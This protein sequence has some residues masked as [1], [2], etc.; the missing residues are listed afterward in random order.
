M[1]RRAI[2]PVLTSGVLAAFAVIAMVLTGVVP[3]SA[4]AP[5]ASQQTFLTF[6]GWWDNTPPG[7]DISHPGKHQTAGGVGTFDDP[8]TFATSTKEV[9]PGG[10]IYVPRVG[11]Y[12]IMEDDCD[13]CSSDWNGKGPNGGPKLAHF[14][15][16]LGGKGG[17]PFKAIQCE[18]ALTHYNKDNTPTMEP[19]IVDPGSGEKVSKDPI[20]N[21]KTGACYG[22]AT[23]TI[24]VGPYKNPASAVCLD[25]PAGATKL[26][27]K[28][29]D[30]SANQ[31]FTFDGTFLSIRNLCADSK[32]GDIALKKCTGGP[33]QQW[34]ANPSGTISDIQTGKKCF[35]ATKTAVTAGS[36]SG[37]AAQWT[38]PAA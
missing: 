6:Y 10:K 34:S 2:V 7:G 21:T 14:D 31:N 23:P 5:H 22:G 8:I 12:F 18:V 32:S 15:L 27:V 28:A 1:R 16:W 4:A 19:V 35:R 38:F 24:T 13:E 9:K 25:A 11:K 20:F 33:T 37:S 30:G 17:D 3:A 29:C 36:C 26:G